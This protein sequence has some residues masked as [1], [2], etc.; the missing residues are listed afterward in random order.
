M[1]Q[2]NFEKKEEKQL[3][4]LAIDI[5]QSE[6]ERI[7][8]LLKSYFRVRL[9]KVKEFMNWEAANHIQDSYIFLF[10]EGESHQ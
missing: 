4:M 6:I 10:K 2:H 7:S 8:Y 5:Y 9:A 1:N 3:Q